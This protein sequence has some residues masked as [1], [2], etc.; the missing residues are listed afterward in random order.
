MSNS[1]NVNLFDAIL[2]PTVTDQMEKVI[3]CKHQCRKKLSKIDLTYHDDVVANMY[4][5][6]QYAFSKGK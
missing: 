6:L 3:P 5:H 4:H 2:L 1:N